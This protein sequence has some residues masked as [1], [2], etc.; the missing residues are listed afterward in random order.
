[1]LCLSRYTSL[2]KIAIL[3]FSVRGI[4]ELYTGEYD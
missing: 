3:Y 1:M 4:V 2:E